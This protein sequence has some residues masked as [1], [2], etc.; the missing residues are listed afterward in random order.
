MTRKQ[1]RHADGTRCHEGTRLVPNG[2]SP[3]CPV[4]AA[5]VDTCHFDVRYEWWSEARL[6]VTAISESAGGGGV[7]IS[8]CPHCGRRLRPATR[9][10]PRTWR[11]GGQWGRYLR[12]AFKE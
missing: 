6:W 7:A 2:F 11:E 10:Q 3:C 1:R 9:R 8:F 5:H 12:L 4:F